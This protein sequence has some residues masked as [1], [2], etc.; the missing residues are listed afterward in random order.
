[1]PGDEAGRGDE[2]LAALVVWLR[3]ELA[4]SQA[5]L[6]RAGGPPAQS[7]HMEP[8]WPVARRRRR[9]RA[10]PIHSQV[11]APARASGDAIDRADRA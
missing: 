2:V 1:M 11:I 3:A 9:R 4:G 7:M 10:L 8:V 5:A 6:G